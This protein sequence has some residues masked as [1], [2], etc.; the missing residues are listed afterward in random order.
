[1][2]SMSKILGK[3]ISRSLLMERMFHHFQQL[4]PKGWQKKMRKR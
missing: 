3:E 4:F 1:M 2:T